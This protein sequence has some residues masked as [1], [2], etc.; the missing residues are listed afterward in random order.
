MTDTSVE[1][2]RLSPQ[3]R[4]IWS[5]CQGGRLF[6]RAQCVLSLAGAL[7]RERLRRAAERLVAT[8]EILRTAFHRR[9]GMRFP[10]QVIAERGALSWQTIDLSGGASDPVAAAGELMRQDA[11]TPPDLEHG[12]LLRLRL[13]PLSEEKHLLLFAL[14]TLCADR[15]TLHNIAIQLAAFYRGEENEAGPEGPIQYADFSQWQ[16]DLLEPEDEAAETARAHW[17]ASSASPATLPFETGGGGSGDPEETIL[18]VSPAVLRKIEGFCSDQ[19]VSAADFL[20]ACWQTLLWRTTG[21][22]DLLVREV[23]DGRKFEELKDALGLFARALPLPARFDGD[24]QFSEIVKSAMEARRRNEEWCEYFEW[25]EELEPSEKPAPAGF[26]FFRRPE[27]PAGGGLAFSIVSESCSVDAFSAWLLCEQAKEG[28]RLSCGADPRILPA[29]AAERLA[30]HLEVL[31]AAAS[32]SPQA[33]AGELPLLTPRERRRLLVDLSRTEAGSPDS[34]CVHEL[35]ESQA[36]RTPEAAALV[37]REERLT[38][39]ELN[40]RA[41]ALAWRLAERGIGPDVGVGLALERSAEMI[42]AL[43]G[44]LKAGGA[45]VPLN[46]EHP[47]ARLSLQL[48]QSGSP[49]VVTQSA[50]LDKFADFAGEKICLD[51]EDRLSTERRT[52]NPERRATPANLVYVMHTSGSTGIPKGVAVRH[53]SLANYADFVVRRLLE[54]DPPPDSPLSFATV[55]TLSAD[56]GNTAIFPSL[57]SGGCLHV[58]DYE[59]AMEGARFADYL[60]RNP[61]DVLKIVPSHLAA[62]L[63]SGE[64]AAVLPRRFLILGGEALTWDL[65]ERIRS[66]GATC[67]IVNHYGPTE[68]TVGSLTFRVPRTGLGASPTVPIGRPIAATQAFVLDA[69]KEP[70]PVGIPGELY[71]G[72][73]GLAQGYCN[74]PEETAERFVPD[75]FSGSAGARLYR[76]G[77]RVRYLPDDNVEF[78]GRVDDQV[79]IRGFRIEPGEVQAVM[80]AH[81]S[82]RETVVVARE[83][84]PGDRRLVAYV[85]PARGAPLSLEELRGWLKARLPDYMVP[86]AFVTMKALPLTGN[87]KV[88]RRALP[89]PEQT[90]SERVYVAPRSGAEQ[91]IA[92]IWQE[93]LRVEKVG[94]DDNFFDLGGHSLLVTQVVS[95]LRK[96]FGRELPIR[97]IFEAPTVAELAARTEAAEREEITRILDELEGLSEKEPD[98]LKISN[99]PPIRA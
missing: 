37:F 3:Q 13:A 24:P 38:Y 4:R 51:R 92:G 29:D 99:E 25:D 22:S 8:H 43:L 12:P 26:E 21:A 27:L 69:A 23:H 48:A 36:E 91:V 6:G 98:R 73:A 44:I 47:A 17:R 39:A 63:N 54:S 35:F 56:L 34:R 67:E 10:F 97:W 93:V 16:N 78:L 11:E 15:G 2:Y 61:I 95:R 62:L 20:L 14:P 49:L 82:I 32:E 60:S 70:V 96:A 31:I 1:G 5:L 53:E 65:V 71:I 79:K 72:G 86:S 18:L 58:V 76:T 94:T 19:G 45:Y 59:T 7:D 80:A 83:D 81:P 89:A 85:V 52:G 64:G 28:L 55:S 77:D 50:W 75:P 42:V 40:A 41:N 46:L 84:S 74:Q 33:R 87:G 90:R 68:T 9:P 88:D 57:I 66:L 30:S